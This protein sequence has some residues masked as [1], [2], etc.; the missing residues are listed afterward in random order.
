MGKYSTIWPTLKVTSNTITRQIP[1]TFIDYDGTIIETMYLNLGEIP[2]EKIDFDSIV[3][4]KRP[5]TEQYDYTFV[6]WDGEKGIPA[7]NP[8]TYVA[9][10]EQSLVKYTVT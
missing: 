7:A 6:G 9:T 8:I 2:A 4:P 5:S 10:Y 1:V 3:P